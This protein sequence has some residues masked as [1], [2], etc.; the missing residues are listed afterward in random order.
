MVWLLILA[1]I[2]LVLSSIKS[3]MTEKVVGFCMLL[4]SDFPTQKIWN[5]YLQKN[6][7]CVMVIHG[8][9]DLKIDPECQ[10]LLKR[11]VILPNPI[12]T[13][14]GGL[15]I[16]KA[17]NVCIRKLLEDQRVHRIFTVSG[18]CIPF[19]SE[20]ELL[21]RTA[22][23]ESIF[24]EFNVPDRLESV[25]TNVTATCQRIPKDAF[26]LHAQWCV[27]TRDHAQILVS[28]ESSY[29]QCFQNTGS[30]VSDETVYLTIL[31]EQK[32]PNIKIIPCLSGNDN[33]IHG[34]TFCHWKN[35]GYKFKSEKDNETISD[36]SP[37]MYND[38]S[39]DEFEHLQKGEYLFARKF[40][41]DTTIGNEKILQYL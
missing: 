38:I 39:K 23:D 17:Q 15:S 27:L 19:R 9:K 18:N 24:T 33:D 26:K 3:A 32:Q 1:C 7:K 41:D 29:A 2:L 25:K 13:Q 12:E 20:D 28:N 34:T 11:A 21:R 14:W 37:K 10:E 30:G 6:P 4:K 8:K 36:S 22:A 40:S 16:V 31:R 5:Q 35:V